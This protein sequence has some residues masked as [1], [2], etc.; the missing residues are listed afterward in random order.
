MYATTVESIGEQQIET[1]GP[2]GKNRKA[3]RSVER[4]VFNRSDS[5]FY[6]LSDWLV[7]S[8]GC[9]HRF[10]ENADA[11]VLDAQT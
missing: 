4:R 3:E 1:I 6:H 9:H 7:D 11:T 10:S 2:E 8:A 5:L